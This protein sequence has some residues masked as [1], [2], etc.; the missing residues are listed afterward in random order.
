MSFSRRDLYH[1]I[2]ISDI[3][4]KNLV[5]LLDDF[6]LVFVLIVKPLIKHLGITKD[7]RKNE[8]Q[9]GPKLME[10]V[11]QGRT[12]DQE[13]VLGVEQSD[14]LGQGGVFVLDSMGLINNNVL[15]SN[16]FQGGLLSDDHFEGGDQDVEVTRHDGVL[17]EL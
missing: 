11:L 12:S 14:D 3:P 9:Q 17:D 16:L 5:Q 13:T 4:T 6:F 7:I 10:V 15:P 1:L 8:V 2:C